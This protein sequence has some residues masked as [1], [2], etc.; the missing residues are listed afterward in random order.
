MSRGRM[1]DVGV[2]VPRWNFRP[3]SLPD[4]HEIAMSTSIEVTDHHTPDL[5]GW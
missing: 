4:I 5:T 1:F 3:V 2:D